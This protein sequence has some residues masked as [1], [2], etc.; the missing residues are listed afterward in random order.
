MMKTAIITGASSGIGKAAAYALVEEGFAVIL[1]AR[2]IDKLNELKSELLSKGHKAIAV[3]ADVT[4][5]NDMKEVAKAALDEFGQIDVLVNNAGIMPLSFL[6]NL[7]ED[8][9]EQTI[10]VNVK[11]VVNSIAAVLPAMME[12]KNGHIVNISSIAGISVFPSAAVYCGTKY[13]V[14]AITEGIRLELTIPYNIRATSIRPGGVETNLM[15][16]ITD[17][18]VFAAFEPM[19]KSV[20]FLDSDDIAKAIVY[21]VTQDPNVS[22]D[23][24]CVRPSNQLM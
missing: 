9:W 18:E 16:T 7:H 1:S 13:A 22:I 23:H 11:G 15:S 24:V 14:E 4:K 10:D 3:K 8:E 19:L 20:K 17:E 12:Q 21:A 5:R 6:K 2:S